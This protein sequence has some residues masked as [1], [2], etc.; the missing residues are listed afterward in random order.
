MGRLDDAVTWN[1]GVL[2]NY[3]VWFS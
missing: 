3:F 1:L 2:S